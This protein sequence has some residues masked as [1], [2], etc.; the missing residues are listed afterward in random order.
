[1][2]AKI[3]PSNAC[4]RITYGHFISILKEIWRQ[5]L[6][7]MF[8]KRV[9]FTQEMLFRPWILTALVAAEGY[10]TQRRAECKALVQPSLLA[11]D[12]K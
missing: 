3:L 11:R 4:P 2:N 9:S 12:R 5:Q 6:D 1:M 8:P 7:T 10:C